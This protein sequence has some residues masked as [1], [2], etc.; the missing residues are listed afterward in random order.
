V[1]LSSRFAASGSSC[2]L[3]CAMPLAPTEYYLEALCRLHQ[4]LLA[5]PIVQTYLTGTDI[6]NDGPTLQPSDEVILPFGV[7]SPM[8]FA[9]LFCIYNG[10][11]VH[12][13]AENMV[14]LDQ[15]PVGLYFTI[16]NNHVLQNQHKNK[17]GLILE[18]AQTP[19]LV[20]QYLFTEHFYLNERRTPRKLGT[21]SFALCAI[22]AHLAGLKHIDLIAAGGE[23]FEKRHIG[24]MFWPTL[25]FDGPIDPEETANA[26]HLHGC[27]TVQEVLLV[28]A[29]WWEDN[30]SQRRMRFDL[31]PQSKSWLKLIHY[32]RSKLS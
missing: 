23:G 6:R 32:A 18:D 21:F 13:Q 2:A 30:G 1:E 15:A 5:E 20:I 16:I 4:A 12:R 22:T 24:Y 11:R 9:H 26:A 17:F 3:N 7:L 8:E 25:G 31:V 19:G 10:S 29:K 14:S 28:D 27:K